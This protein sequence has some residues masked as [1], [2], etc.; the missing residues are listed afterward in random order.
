MTERGPRIRCFS[1]TSAAAAMLAAFYRDALGFVVVAQEERGGTAFAR[2]MGLADARARAVRLRLGRQEVELLS[3]T[4]AGKPYPAEAASNDT[5]FQHMAIVVADMRAAFARLS[6]QAGWTPITRPEPQRLPDTSGGVTAFKFRDPEGHPLELLE[7]PTDRVPAAWRARG[8]DAALGIDHSA[9]TVAETATSV[10]FYTG[11]LGFA[12]GG[13]SLNHGIEQERLDGVPGAVVTVTAL[14]SGAMAPPHLEL[15]C[16]RATRRA[17]PAQ[18]ND[19]AAMRLVIEVDDVPATA[20]RLDQAGT[21]FMS[22]GV[23]RGEALLRDPDGHALW[24]VNR[25]RP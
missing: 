22:P 4:A 16:Y 20:A 1:L 3:F 25:P 10:A 12:A 21:L 8:A 14:L 24:I 18:S 7:F 5:Q 11:L 6:A 19:V 9:I 15:L 23:A 17:P 2:L 13:G